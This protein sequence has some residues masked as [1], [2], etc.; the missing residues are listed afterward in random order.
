M[1][2][3]ENFE[4]RRQNI[5]FEIPAN[6]ECPG[7]PP[8]FSK[9]NEEFD[10][11]FLSY[12]H[13]F[14]ILEPDNLVQQP[15]SYKRKNGT[16]NQVLGTSCS[17]KGPKNL[18]FIK[19]NN[20][21]DLY[22]FDQDNNEKSFKIFRRSGKSRQAMGEWQYVKDLSANDGI[23]DF[24]VLRE[25]LNN[26]WCYQYQIQSRIDNSCFSPWVISETFCST[27]TILI[28]P[29][30]TPTP[31]IRPPSDGK[32]NPPRGE[33]PPSS[34]PKICPA[35]VTVSDWLFVNNGINY[36]F[37]D[38][39]SDFQNQ[40]SNFQLIESVDDN[41]G[42][43]R[44]LNLVQGSSYNLR[45]K[46]KISMGEVKIKIGT[47]FEQLLRTNNDWS[48][49]D[50][51][52]RKNS[53]EI[54]TIHILTST[55]NTRFFID[56][57]RIFK[58]NPTQGENDTGCQ[59]GS[60]TINLASCP[61]FNNYQNNENNDFAF[62][63]NYVINNFLSRDSQRDK[64]III[65]EGNYYLKTIGNDPTGQPNVGQVRIENVNKLKI[66]GVN[67]DN[68]VL[69][70]KDSYNGINDQFRPSIFEIINSKNIHFTNLTLNFNN[71]NLYDPVAYAEGKF[72]GINGLRANIQE[73]TFETV[74]TVTNCRFLS[75]KKG[76]GSFISFG[77]QNGY[78]KFVIENNVFENYW[79]AVVIS[80]IG[81]FLIKRNLF[82]NSNSY[83]FP[84]N[85]QGN[86]LGHYD[87]GVPQ[88]NSDL[89]I[90]LI[91]PNNL[92]QFESFLIENTFTNTRDGRNLGQNAVGVVGLSHNIK[93]INNTFKDHDDGGIYIATHVPG[94]GTKRNYC[95][96]GGP[97]NIVIENN[98]LTN[99]KLSAISITNLFD[100]DYQHPRLDLRCNF[101]DL[102]TLAIKNVIIRNN[103][104]SGVGTSGIH[105]SASEKGR[106]YNLHVLNNLIQN[107]NNPEWQI[108][109][110][111]LAAM[112]S[113]LTLEGLVGENND[114]NNIIIS[115]NN[116][117]NC[118]N[119][120]YFRASS[121]PLYDP[122]NPQYFGI[123]ESKYT[124]EN[125]QP[126]R[127]LVFSN[128]IIENLT[129]NQGDI[130]V[131]K[132][133]IAA[134]NLSRSARINDYRLILATNNQI[135][136]TGRCNSPCQ[137]ETDCITPFLPNPHYSGSPDSPST[138]VFQGY[139][140][141]YVCHQLSN[142]NKVCRNQ[143]DPSD[144]DCEI[145]SKKDLTCTFLGVNPSQ[146]TDRF[147]SINYS[148]SVNESWASYVKHKSLTNSSTQPSAP[149]E[150]CYPSQSNSLQRNCTFIP[151]IT[152]GHK[153]YFIGVN[154]HKEINN[155]LYICDWK[156]RWVNQNGQQI[157]PPPGYNDCR[158]DCEILISV[159]ISGSGSA[160]PKE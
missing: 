88:G 96:K 116:I 74:V 119:G 136:G 34:S 50:F 15:V 143:E 97:K 154:L 93:I 47:D 48:N 145:T 39:I 129:P 83:I 87:Q 120:V 123:P 91:N 144:S 117:R 139:P 7:K 94:G 28:T 110:N 126:N 26:N 149:F 40:T 19:E 111:P 30:P 1:I 9:N 98:Q 69:N 112:R 92:S 72:R 82:N 138:E 31:T 133:P 81:S 102:N 86:P 21:F 131:Q 44:T 150:T 37:L 36:K 157:S 118:S 64:T 22:A 56:D 20:F 84:I 57:I 107:A 18:R 29:T 59:P 27:E 114:F 142:D 53:N 51:T 41:V 43:K 146:I 90:N 23:G 132:I 25:S 79:F 127:Y 35:G 106:I 61:N 65:P 85:D 63:L 125:N 109:Q 108:P 158:N 24:F 12:F 151:V 6:Y 89:V 75:N 10:S 78:G 5:S 152:P 115:G 80:N 137:S 3:E 101:N 103:N 128:N 140:K 104:I 42:I 2:L 62:Y 99:I 147:A 13:S 8:I 153:S 134:I 54:S 67:R 52:F 105:I 58:L 16:I 95:I 68:T 121:F 66:S 14:E 45:F 46:I 159:G 70:I 33:E 122:E 124:S 76:F 135:K 141:K 32:N 100:P 11:R 113:C 160:P 71:N 4:S 73:N 17:L 55:P 49:F 156:N 77:S 148:F 155:N 130:L 38:L 60:L